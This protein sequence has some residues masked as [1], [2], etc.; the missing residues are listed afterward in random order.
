MNVCSECEHCWPWDM[1]ASTYYELAVC[2]KSRIGFV[3]DGVLSYERCSKANTDGKCSEF[4]PLRDL[5]DDP[6]D[7]DPDYC[8]MRNALSESIQETTP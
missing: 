4:Q 8:Q 2:K 3:H 6:I 5:R 7:P 1:K